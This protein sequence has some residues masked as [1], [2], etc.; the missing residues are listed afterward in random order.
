MNIA[1]TALTLAA[2]ALSQA[3]ALAHDEDLRSGNL[4]PRIGRISNEVAQLKLRT[5]GLDRPTIVSRDGERIVLNA[6]HNGQPISLQMNALTGATTDAADTSLALASIVGPA[7]GDRIARR[8]LDVS[9]ARISDRA[10]IEGA[11]APPR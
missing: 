10:L 1:R 3:L 8:Q 2:L 11:V 7:A 4:K 5:Y 9:R 6:L